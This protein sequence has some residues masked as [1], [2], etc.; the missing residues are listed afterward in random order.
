MSENKTY[1]RKLLRKHALGYDPETIPK[2]IYAEIH[3]QDL[4][5]KVRNPAYGLAFNYAVKAF[6]I[7]VL[8]TGLSII[9]QLQKLEGIASYA[10]GTGV[11]FLF[12]WLLLRSVR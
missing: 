7:G 1:L 11:F 4:I 10:F 6:L 2:E 9:P 5:N 8:C 3:K 12:G